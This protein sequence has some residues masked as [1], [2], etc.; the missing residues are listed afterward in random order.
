M[1]AQGVAATQHS[2]GVQEMT[3]RIAC[4]TSTPCSAWR[5]EKSYGVS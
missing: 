2:D 5:C 4:T 1:P 3:P